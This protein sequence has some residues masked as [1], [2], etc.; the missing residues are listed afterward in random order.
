MVMMMMMM[1]MMMMMMM[2]PSG[3]PNAK[4]SEQK[5]KQLLSCIACEYL[6]RD[7]NHMIRIIKIGFFLQDFP[8]LAIKM[9]LF[10]EELFNFELIFYKVFF[11]FIFSAKTKNLVS[12]AGAFF[13][14]II[15]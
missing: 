2:K 6:C 11:L 7:N 9:P 3:C 13:T 10:R 14:L 12:Q 8:N 4:P 5:I 15:S 1:K